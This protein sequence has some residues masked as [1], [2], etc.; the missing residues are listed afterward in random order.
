MRSIIVR[1]LLLLNLGMQIIYAGDD[2][3]SEY[4]ESPVTDLS[5][6]SEKLSDTGSVA[7]NPS[8]KEISSN[9]IQ[10]RKL[11]PITPDTLGTGALEISVYPKKTEV[12]INTEK[13]GSGNQYL[14]DLRSGLYKISLKY[15]KKHISE[16][17]LVHSGEIVNKD[18]VLYRKLQFIIEPSFSIVWARRTHA[19]G[20]SLDLGLQYENNYYGLN[21]FW[22]FAN[23]RA[24]T[25]GGSF[26]YYHTFNFGEILSIGPGICTGFWY[27]GGGESTGYYYENCYP[28]C[29]DENYFDEFFFGGLLVKTKIGYG[30]F[31]TIFTYTFLIGTETGHSI[32]FGLQ[33]MI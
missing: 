6:S 19:I 22:D 2:S 13:I 28:S 27:Y 33:F 10:P 16:Y 17:V 26:L 32:Q 5:V 15:N 12:L 25:L 7:L 20:P 14:K 8:D 30:R 18:Y 4:S 1:L 31:F 11:T 3:L 29:G 23:D 24:L 9:G 21:Y